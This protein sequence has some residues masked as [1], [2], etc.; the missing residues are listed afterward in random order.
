MP[1]G[2]FPNGNGSAGDCSKCWSGSWW[3]SRA[4]ANTSARWTRP[5]RLAAED[6]WRE[7]A[8]REIMRLCHLLGRG[9]QALRQYESC[10]QVLQRELGSPPSPE[11]VA[12]AEEIAAR[13][14]RPASVL[15]PAVPRPRGT[16]RLERPDQLPLAGR[17][18]ELAELLCLVDSA[19]LAA[20]AWRLSTARPAWARAACCANSPPM[21][22]GA[23]CMSSGGTATSWLPRW[24]I[25]RL[26]RRCARSW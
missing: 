26:S 5:K 24:P 3:G 1:T 20:G 21:R 17:R 25:S 6:P 9:D 4:A 22:S 12:L 19:V 7:E 8:H 2:R 14:G 18:A 10:R 16:L 15:L 23:A 13:A 11:T